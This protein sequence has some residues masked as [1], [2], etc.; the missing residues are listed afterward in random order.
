MVYNYKEYNHLFDT[1]AKHQQEKVIVDKIMSL[2]NNKKYSDLEDMLGK[3]SAYKNFL[4]NQKMDVVVKHFGNTLTENDYKQIIEQMRLLTKNKNSFDSS[5]INSINVDDKEYI[6]FKGNNKT[7][8]INNSGESKSIERQM[9]DLQ[10]T[11]RDFQTADPSK[12]TEN[13]FKEFENHIK[14]NLNF[15]YLYEIDRFKL[16]PEKQQI[17]DAAVNYQLVKKEVIKLDIDKEII[18]DNDE[19]ILQI[20]K[21]NDKLIVK[22]DKA[23]S[24]EADNEIEFEMDAHQKQFTLTPN[25]TNSNI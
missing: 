23:E 14:E 18:L 13:M 21:I 5:K 1:P 16:T 25:V 15:Y 2:L 22:S 9:K 20:S 8:F 7:Y 12:N 11:N 17:Y 4:N 10:K 6:S 3:N 24:N 19:N